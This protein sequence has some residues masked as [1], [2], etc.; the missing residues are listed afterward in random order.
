MQTR[1]GIVKCPI[2]KGD[3]NK[4]EFCPNDTCENCSKKSE[5]EKPGAIIG[6][7]GR[8]ADA[9]L[10][11][12]SIFHE[13]VLSDP[14]F[15]GKAPDITLQRIARDV[16]GEEDKGK[17]NDPAGRILKELHLH[18][19]TKGKIDTALQDFLLSI[20]VT[21]RGVVKTRI[22]EN[23][24][25]EKVIPHLKKILVVPTL[26]GKTS[27]A[28]E[29]RLSRYQESGGE[30]KTYSEIDE[31]DY[32]RK[33]FQVMVYSKILDEQSRIEHPIPTPEDK[34]AKDFILQKR[35][36]LVDDLNKVNVKMR[37]SRPS[38]LFFKA[39]QVVIY[40]ILTEEGKIRREKAKGR[41]AII[42]NEY[43][44][45]HNFPHIANLDSKDIDNAIH[46]A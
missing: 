16:Y 31:I 30:K 27:K 24:K 7:P 21:S 34:Q 44:E 20:Y 43:L 23:R 29:E 1:K 3:V 15:K 39:M 26:L 14:I 12:K 46:S 37:R 38:I 6:R 40:R 11:G 22:K 9:Y 5:T 45:N 19:S 33:S 2:R 8:L 32:F 41:T 10:D 17:K 18:P 4:D 25:M 13:S 36:K 28:V 42:I 35:R